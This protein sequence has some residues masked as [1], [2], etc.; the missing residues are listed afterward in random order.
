MNHQGHHPARW[1]TIT[2]AGGGE[3]VATVAEDIA[4][5]A[6]ITTVTASDADGQPSQS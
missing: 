5:T 1:T 3:P 2:L 6:I 4:D